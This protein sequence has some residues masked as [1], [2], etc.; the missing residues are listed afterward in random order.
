M[1]SNPFVL[2]SVL[3]RVGGLEPGSRI[4]T[5]ELSVGSLYLGTSGIL[6]L[7]QCWGSESERIQTICMIRIRSSRSDLDPDPRSKIL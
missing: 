6:T 2:S 1:N 5:L 4:E 7:Y 3:G